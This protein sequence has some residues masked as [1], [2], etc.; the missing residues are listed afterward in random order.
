MPDW[1]WLSLAGNVGRCA[2]AVL[3]AGSAMAG[4]FSGARAYEHA[5]AMVGFGPRPSGSA[6]M[7]KQQAYIVEQLKAAG[8]QVSEDVFTAKTPVGAVEMRNLIAR[9]QG[10]SGK[11]LAVTGHYDTKRFPFPFVGAND[12]GSSAAL[13][14]EMARA[15]KD[16]KLK[17][18]VYLVFF[19]GEEAVKEWT[20]SDSLYGSRHL[21]DK[22]HSDGTL[23]RMTALIN[24]DMIGDRDLHVVAEQF[25][26]EPLRQT[27]WGV[28]EAMGKGG[29]FDGGQAAIEDDHVPFLRKGV[30][31]LDLIDFQYGPNHG[32]WHTAGDTLDKISASSLETVGSVVLETLKKLDR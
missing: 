2:A 29:S 19:D 9:R 32:W 26:S 31:A 1:R 7:K 18:D 27:L 21:A 16:V 25:S 17:S 11:A 30:R 22:W 4:P 28:A 3:L 23:G 6:A 20:S 14:L 12:A 15:L 10:S 8:W 24:V 13:V 5:K